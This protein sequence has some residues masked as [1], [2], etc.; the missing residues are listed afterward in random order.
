M[1]YIA[2]LCCKLNS[3]SMIYAYIC[4][5]RH[6]QVFCVHFFFFC[7]TNECLFLECHKLITI[8]RRNASITKRICRKWMIKQFAR[9]GENIN[10]INSNWLGVYKVKE[11]NEKKTE[12]KNR[13]EMRCLI[14]LQSSSSSSCLIESK[15]I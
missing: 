9:Q 8:K 15:R 11:T 5:T 7:Q 1:L 4:E 14:I 3:L 10:D 6:R 2:F 13:F 12:R